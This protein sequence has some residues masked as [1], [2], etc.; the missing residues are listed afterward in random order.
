M[1]QPQPVEEV[2]EV[3]ARL[4][5]EPRAEI[6]TNPAA[7]AVVERYIKDVGAFEAQM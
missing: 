3:I 6:F 2:V 5:D 7:G 4:I 1:P